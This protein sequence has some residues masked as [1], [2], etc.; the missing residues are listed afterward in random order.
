LI[1]DDRALR[2]ESGDKTDGVVAENPAQDQ[3]RQQH[4]DSLPNAP[5]E[6][7]AI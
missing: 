2:T 4:T 5:E 6:V 1:D 3:H 7:M